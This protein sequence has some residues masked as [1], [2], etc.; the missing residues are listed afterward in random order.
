MSVCKQLLKVKLLLRLI[1]HSVLK[2]YGGVD[3]FLPVIVGIGTIG[4][5]GSAVHPGRFTPG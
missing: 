1:K 3:V 5:E 4:D 2:T